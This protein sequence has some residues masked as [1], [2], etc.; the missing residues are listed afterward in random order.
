M[1]TLAPRVFI[2]Y[3]DG[4]AERKELVLRFAARLRKNSIDAKVDR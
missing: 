4:S 3:R 1:A 2:T